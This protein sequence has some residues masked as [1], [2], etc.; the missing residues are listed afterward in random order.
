MII[1]FHRGQ[2]KIRG[3]NFCL[4]GM[5]EIMNPVWECILNEV[6]PSIKAQK[7]ISDVP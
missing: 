1:Y 3:G 2:Y 4:D 5:G 7:V 6:S